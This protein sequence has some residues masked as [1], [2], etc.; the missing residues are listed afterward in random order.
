[1]P[2]NVDIESLNIKEL[3]VDYANRQGIDGDLVLSLYKALLN[4]ENWKELLD[5]Y[6]NT[7][8]RG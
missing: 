3:L 6:Y 2:D 1:M 4:N 5:E 8:F 7:K